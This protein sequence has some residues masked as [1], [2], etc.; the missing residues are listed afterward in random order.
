M[1]LSLGVN[2]GCL[3]EGACELDLESHIRGFLGKTRQRSI[4]VSILWCIPQAFIECLLHA[5]QR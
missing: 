2:E 5:R 4:Q 1:T 3:E